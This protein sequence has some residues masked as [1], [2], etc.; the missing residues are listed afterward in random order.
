VPCPHRIKVVVVGKDNRP[1]TLAQVLPPNPDIT[2]LA[3]AQQLEPNVFKNASGEFIAVGPRG[4]VRRYKT[5]KV[6]RRRVQKVWKIPF[7]TS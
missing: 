5:L 4:G 3:D 2:G 6:A 1:I 7:W